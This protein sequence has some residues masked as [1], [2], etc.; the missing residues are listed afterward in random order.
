MKARATDGISILSIPTND[1]TEQKVL[2]L[3]ANARAI[4]RDGKKNK[5]LHAPLYGGGAYAPS[6][7]Q[8]FKHDEF[9][10]VRPKKVIKLNR[11]GGKL[12]VIWPVK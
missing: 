9:Q 12:Q 11:M 3:L 5:R 2:E 7:P 6:R 10:S 4:R 8:Q 1:Q